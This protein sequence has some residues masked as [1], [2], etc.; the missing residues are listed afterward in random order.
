M[1][2]SKATRATLAKI[3]ANYEFIY[4]EMLSDEAHDIGDASDADE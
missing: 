4:T 2:Y 1:K 3:N